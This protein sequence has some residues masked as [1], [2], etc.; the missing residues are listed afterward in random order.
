MKL[1]LHSCRS[2]PLAPADHGQDGRRIG[3]IHAPHL[4][5]PG[6]T[7]QADTPGTLPGGRG[8]RTGAPRKFTTEQEKKVNHK[9]AGDSTQTQLQST[10]F[11]KY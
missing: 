9:L 5:L 7:T 8:H 10:K 6:K 11:E 4:R 3:N 1:T 2:Q